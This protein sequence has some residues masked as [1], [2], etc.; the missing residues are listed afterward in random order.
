MVEQ[1]SPLE[2]FCSYAHQ[3][4]VWLRKLVTHL[5]L[6]E[7]EGL[8]LIWHDRL[9]T[10]GTDWAQEIDDRLNRARLI[11]LL[12]SPDF[13]ASDYCYGIEMQQALERHEANEARVVPVLVRPVGNWQIAPFARLQALPPGKF[14]VEWSEREEDIPLAQIANGLR[15]TVQDLLSPVASVPRANQP[16]LWTVPYP[17]NPLFTG[18]EAELQAI[19]E[20]FSA[21]QHAAIVQAQAISGLGGIGKT[22]LALEYAYR[23]RAAYRFVFWVLADTRD[24]L[25]A[26]YSELAEMLELPERQQRE[27]SL[28]VAAVKGWLAAHQGWLLILDNADDLSVVR[29]FLPA[30]S[31]GHIL[32]TTRAHAMGRL[33]RRIEV[34]KLLVEEGSRFLL[35]RSG[36]LA[37]QR[38][39]EDADPTT[40]SIVTEIVRELDGLPL[41]LDQAGAYIEET[42]CSLQDYLDLYRTQ[43]AE[44]L[45]LRGGLVADHPEPVAT[46]WQLAFDRIEA[47]N[48]AAAD[49]LR[50]C[51]FLAPD[52]I[53][54]MIIGQGMITLTLPLRHL[55]ENPLQLNAALAALQ[56]YSLVTRHPDTHTLDMHRLVQAVLRDAMSKEEERAWAE[57]AVQAMTQIFPWPAV[58]N[59]EVC[60]Q[61]LPHAQACAAL[62]KEWQLDMREAAYMLNGVGYYMYERAEY[63]GAQGYLEQSLAIYRK[64][65]GNEHVDTLAVLN[66]LANSYALQGRDELAST[67]Y[68]QV[69]AIK[70]KML[71]AENLSTVGTLQNLANVCYKQ[72]NYEEA[73][74]L[75]R[76]ALNIRR[77]IQGEDH[78]E[79]VVSLNNLAVVYQTLRRYEEAESTHQHTLDIRRKIL[80]EDHPETAVS[81]RN[82]ALV[83][84]AQ[85]RYGEALQLFERALIIDQEKLGLEHPET[86]RA[87]NNVEETLQAM[88]RDAGENVEQP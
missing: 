74:L 6:L 12:I 16:S 5:R 69:L 3:D 51:A 80:G 76:R 52:D 21:G 2:V 17:R 28:I 54:E 37:E 53:P 39:L 26:A 55:A 20:A 66:N 68:Q 31:S 23:H 1:S 83:Y 64:M 32:L 35:H 7:R 65:S 81:L 57:R 43:R 72:G 48:V 22:Q 59:W 84:Q 71:G 36:L 63:S 44:L 4:E 11:L 78:P 47:D 60:R 25:N 33:A 41:A 79:T 40:R 56:R 29:D 34:K 86:K 82:L 49:L 70:E 75:H 88:K 50:L 62:I 18:R 15:A 85:G 9:L 87:Q 42:N 67:F 30:H 77:K 10:A 8:V 38:T 27:Q 61:L 58:A 14:I 46:T 24:T 45:R 13:V 73:L 19:E